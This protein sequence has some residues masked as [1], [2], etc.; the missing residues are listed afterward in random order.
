MSCRKKDC[1]TLLNT[2]HYYCD[3]HLLK[4]QTKKQILINKRLND[5][6]YIHDTKL[7]LKCQDQLSMYKWPDEDDDE[8]DIN[9]MAVNVHKKLFDLGYKE[10]T[11]PNRLT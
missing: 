5:P 8:D 2:H 4:Q 6:C 10:H 9:W 1:N 3:E 11:S 7:F